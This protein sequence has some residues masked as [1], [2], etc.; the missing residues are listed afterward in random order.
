MATAAPFRIRV[1]DPIGAEGVDKVLVIVQ[2]L[3]GKGEVLR[4]LTDPKGSITPIDLAPGLYRLIATYPY[5]YWFT[6]VREFVVSAA[7][8]NM[9]LHMDGAVIDRV[10]A[11]GVKV[12]V[13]VVNRDGKAIKNAHILGRDRQALSNRWDTTDGQGHAV[14]TV[15][16]NGADIVAIYNEQVVITPIDIPFSDTSCTDKE[17]QMRAV[18]KVEEVSRNIT[19]RLN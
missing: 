9:D 15:G 6:Q 19:V 4:T 3:D 16:V 5:G 1:T 18:Q 2:S 17:C 7:P 8:V 10:A 13:T 11:P 14:V 12:Q